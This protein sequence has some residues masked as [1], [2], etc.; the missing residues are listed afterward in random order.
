[1]NA[2]PFMTRHT[3]CAISLALGLALGALLSGCDADPP[4]APDVLS[5]SASGPGSTLNAPS[6]TQAAAVSESRIDVAWQDNSP[7]ESGFEMHRA[8]EGGTFTLLASMGAGATSYTDVGLA[9][10]TRYC[11]KV[12][13]FKT[14]GRNTSYSSFSATACATTLPPPAPPAAPADLTAEA[15]T[16]QIVLW[17][18]PNSTDQDGF[19]IERCQGIVCSEVDFAVIATTDKNARSYGDYGAAWGTTYTYR[20]RAFNGAGDSA[21]SNEA[22]ATACFVELADDGSYYCRTP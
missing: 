9:A 2:Q 20:V 4:L 7:N 3:R 16:W 13:A 5:A 15:V 6:G 17:W 11:Y 1:M 8:T 21:P 14:A 18:L 19:R 22:S 10:A 12:R